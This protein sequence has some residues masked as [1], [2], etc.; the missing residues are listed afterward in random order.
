KT[1]VE[2]RF[3]LYWVERGLGTA[4]FFLS[5]FSGILGMD[6]G[7]A[8]DS[9]RALDLKMISKQSKLGVFGELKT[10]LVVAYFLP[11]SV[12][13]GYG[14]GLINRGENQIYCNISSS[15]LN[16]LSEKRR[17]SRKDINNLILR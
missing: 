8:W 11:L 14:F 10:S 1:T 9:Y 3:P 15:I 16:L 12:K 5:N 7:L 17:L 2:Y 6:Y 4:P 13:I